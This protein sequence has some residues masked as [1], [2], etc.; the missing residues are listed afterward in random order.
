MMVEHD[1]GGVGEAL[2]DDV[3]GVCVRAPNLSQ[4]DW[5]VWC[6]GPDAGNSLGVPLHERFVCRW[7]WFVKEFDADHVCEWRGLR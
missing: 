6:N 3:V 7:C 5:Y 2:R 4:V 1:E